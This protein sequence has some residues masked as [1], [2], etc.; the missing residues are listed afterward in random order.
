MGI[1]NEANPLK[2]YYAFNGSAVG[3]GGLI[4]FGIG[5]IHGALA[6]WRYEFLVVGAVCAF[7][8]IVLALLLPNSP[9]TF[10][11]FTREEKLL[12]IARVRK[13]Q[14]GV[15]QRH[16][17]WSQVK[18]AYL[19]YKVWLFTLLG[20]FANIPN[21]GIS[22]FSTL[23]IQGLG[24]DTYH[25][26]LLGIPQGMLIGCPKTR[27]PLTTTRCD[28]CHLDRARRYFGTVLAQELAYMGLCPIHA[29]HDFRSPRIPPRPC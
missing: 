3:L 5:H 6:S 2:F 22:N 20:F 23:V 25:T 13:N 4:G 15:E 1:E 28:H 16:I 21:G 8:G 10:W 12:M 27:P 14:T 7:W 18:E 19:D 9:A 26:A 24:F 11:G 17:N 29:S